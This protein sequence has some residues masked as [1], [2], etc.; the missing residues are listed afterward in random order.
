MGT[1]GSVTEDID[2]ESVVIS[3]VAIGMDGLMNFYELQN[4]I[5][6]T[7]YL[8]AFSNYIKP[9]INNVSPYLVSGSDK[10]LNKFENKYTKGTTVTANGFY[11]PQG[12]TLRARNEFSHLVSAFTKFKHKHFSITNLEMETA[13]IYALGRILG[14]NCLSINAILANRVKQ[15][16]SSNPQKVVDQMIADSL[17]I[18]T[19]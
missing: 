12:R 19:A 10:L 5:W 17:E 8:E 2:I 16:F 14:H 7:V 1:S 3:E 9:Y 15:T 11:G 6:E 18:I 13:G 4:T